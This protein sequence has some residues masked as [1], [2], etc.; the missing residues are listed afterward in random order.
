MLQTGYKGC[1]YQFI[2]LR[3]WQVILFLLPLIDKPGNTFGSK[4]QVLVI[5]VA[6]ARY[7]ILGSVENKLC[8]EW[9][10]EVWSGLKVLRMEV[11]HCILG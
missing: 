3:S 6:G 2:Y 11:K 1:Q 4:T 9:P 5:K 8:H 7:D 10:T